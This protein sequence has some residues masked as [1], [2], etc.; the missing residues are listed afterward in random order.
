MA[1]LKWLFHR[2]IDQNELKR[3]IGQLWELFRECLISFKQKVGITTGIM[4]NNTTFRA[5]KIKFER[6]N[7]ALL[8]ELSDE[9]KEAKI[10]SLILRSNV[11][12]E[13]EKR[14]LG[15][16]REK[17]KVLRTILEQ[18][19]QLFEEIIIIIERYKEKRLPSNSGVDS[20]SKRLRELFKEEHTLMFG[21][22]EV[23]ELLVKDIIENREFPPGLLRD[24]CSK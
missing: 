17:L 13:Q 15:L 9:Q 20:L 21:E 11:L 1:L 6:L 14:K 24:S 3:E 12:T 16:V 19:L 23:L 8:K 22:D 4:T 18:Q 10:V 5:E 7:R 2:N